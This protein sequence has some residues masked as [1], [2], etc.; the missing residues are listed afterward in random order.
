VVGS[1]DKCTVIALIEDGVICS[2]SLDEPCEH[3]L[4]SCRRYALKDPSELAQ[5]EVRLA[6]A[7]EL[8]AKKDAA[9]QE[10]LS[11]CAVSLDDPR[12]KYVEVQMSKGVLEAVRDALA[13]TLT[14][15]SIAQQAEDARIGRA[16]EEWHKAHMACLA[17]YPAEEL[18]DVGSRVEINMTRVIGEVIAKAREVKS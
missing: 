3:A 5:V 8:L 12:L 13:F 1:V 6:A 10:V 2:C 16:V 11:E 9:L 7:E 14:P 4:S 15:V 18:K 17:T